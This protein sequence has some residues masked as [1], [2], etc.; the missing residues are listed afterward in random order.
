M[1]KQVLVNGFELAYRDA[2]QGKAILL[3]HAFPL[4]GV[5]WIPQLEEWRQSY[6]VIAPDLRGVGASAGGAPTDRYCSVD[7]YAHDMAALLKSLDVSQAVVLGLSMGGYVAFALYRNYPEMVQALVLCDTRSET[8]TPEG[9]EARYKMIEAVRAQGSSVAAETMLPKLFA[10]DTYKLRPD[11]VAQVGGL[12]ENNNPAGIMA[13]AGALAERPDSTPTL[14]RINVPTL[15]VVG[16]DDQTVTVE[17]ARKMAQ[18]IPDWQLS[19]VPHAGHLSNLENPEF[20]N[21]A[22]ETFLKE[23]K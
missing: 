3:L 21:Q 15:V 23:L 18:A 6:R 1:M 13:G 17:T 20:F 22:V 14:A 4:S 7:E 9:R 2:G 19:V 8:D 16:R 12:I 5:M 11:L 10:P